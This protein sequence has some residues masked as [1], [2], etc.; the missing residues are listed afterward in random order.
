[1][2]DFPCSFHLNKNNLSDEKVRT[3]TANRRPTLQWMFILTRPLV[4]SGAKG[5]LLAFM[6]SIMAAGG[7]L[8]IVS[9]TGGPFGFALALPLGAGLVDLTAD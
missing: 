1:M 5:P 4:L 7:F 6:N 9:G 2:A 3:V 8:G